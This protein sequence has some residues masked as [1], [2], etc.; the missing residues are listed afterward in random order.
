LKLKKFTGVIHLWL[1]MIAGLV[2]VVSMTAAAIFVWEKELT[3]LYYEDYIFVQVKKTPRLPLSRLITLAQNAIPDKPIS[4]IDIKND[5]GRAYIFSSYK[6]NA[7]PTGWT[8]WDDYF[9]WDQIYVDPYTGNVLGVVNMLADPIDLTRRLHQNLLLRY[10]IGHY[11]VGFA[12]VFVMMLILTGL[13]LWWPKNRASLKQR[14][15]IKWS[16]RWRRV[17]YDIHNVGGFYTHLLVLLLAITG[18]VWTFDWWTNGIYRLLGDN[19][20]S[21]FPVHE[22]PEINSPFSNKPVDF[23][24][25]DVITKRAD[26]TSAG[27]Y[28]PDLADKKAEISVYLQFNS[29]SGWDEG[30]Q[31][32]YHPVTGKLFYQRLQQEKPLGAKWRNSNYAIHVGSIYGLPT[33]FLAMFGALFLASM[34]ISGFLIWWGRKQKKRATTGKKRQFVS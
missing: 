3:D 6:E 8:H 23:V 14:F 12:T 30:D 15:T 2:V 10:D 7:S 1:G 4:W 32:A 22:R 31:Y 21:V 18:L 19:P 28:L 13:I 17:N 11:I 9:Y 5:P 33:K 34:P 26:W 27:I 29:D 25:A 24:F 20:A 16:A